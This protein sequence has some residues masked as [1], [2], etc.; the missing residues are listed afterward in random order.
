MDITLDLTVLTDRDHLF[1][2]DRTFKMSVD[3][4]ITLQ[5]YF[6]LESSTFCDNSSGASPGFAI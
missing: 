5:A 1:R 3:I 2:C 6:A 4:D